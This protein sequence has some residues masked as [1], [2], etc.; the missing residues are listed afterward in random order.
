VLPSGALQLEAGFEIARSGDVSTYSLGQTLVR[1]GFAAFELDIFANSF[2]LVRGDLQTASIEQEGFADLGVG[3]KVPVARDVGGRADVS[4]QGI[5]TAPT[6]ATPISTGEWVPSVTAL[7][8]VTLGASTALGLN[9]GWQVGTGALADVVDVIV[10]PGFALGDGF[11][12]YAGWA[13]AF[14]DGGS[15]HILEGGFTYLPAPDVQ[16][17]INSGYDVDTDAWFL[18]AGIAVRRIG[19]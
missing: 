8:D 1:V 14:S 4:L 18:G 6:G 2:V 11:G 19:R 15:T 10:T 3:V 17:D 5:V 9:V 16:L 7:A 13:G 12:G